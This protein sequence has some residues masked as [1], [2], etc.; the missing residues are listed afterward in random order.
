[1]LVVALNYRKA[2]AY[3]FPES[4]HDI[5]ALFVS[6][7]AD[8]SLPI[9]PDRVAMA[10]WSAGGTLALAVSQLE[11]VRSRLQAVVP[12][13]PALD[14]SITPAAKFARR[15]VKTALGGF[16]GTGKDPIIRMAGLFDWCYQPVGHNR[17]DPLLCPAFAD[18]EALPK[19]VFILAAELD[20]LAHESWAL[21]SKL[22]G[23]KAPMSDQ[24][25]GGSEPVG[26]GALVLDDERYAFEERTGDGGR[27]RWLLVPDT[28]HGFDQSI[29]G[30]VRDEE[31]MKDARIKT[32]KTISIIGEWLLGGPLRLDRQT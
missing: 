31:L 13:Y 3:P 32:D 20:M 10:G 2:P 11:G 16:R 14:L 28:V 21:V 5:E 4:I 9:D 25:V 6:V 24:P 8:S 19:N 27:Y 7:L 23:R 29:S 15:R 18:R 1:M 30:L 12:L 26:K 22:A 17:H